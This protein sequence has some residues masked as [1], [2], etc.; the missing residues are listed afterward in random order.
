[1]SALADKLALFNDT[2]P[3][4]RART[5]PADWYFEA[6]VYQAEM[7][8]VFRR[9]W[10]ALGCLG[11]GNYLTGTVADEPVLVTQDRD[12]ALRGFYNVCRHRAATIMAGAGTA[13]KLRCRYHGWTYDLAG[14]LRGTPDFDGVEDFCT[15]NHGLQP[16]RAERFGPLVFLN[17]EDSEPRS[18]TDSLAPLTATMLDGLL[19]QCRKT[20]A[21]PCNWKVFVDNYL[22]GGY[23]V[24]T[25]HPGLA[26]AI[27]YHHYRTLVFEQ[28][29]VQTSPVDSGDALRQGT[30]R[31]WWVFPNLM[32]N[33]YDGLADTNIVV[34]R[35]PDR[36]EVIFD[37][38]FADTISESERQRSIAVA[39]Q[40]QAEDADICAEV[41]QGLHSRSYNT[42][43]FSVKREVAGYH[44][45]RLLVQCL[46]N[47]PASDVGAGAMI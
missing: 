21:V 11:D 23:H 38:Y 15:A 30:A 17:L 36:C 35:G 20:F 27:D 25:I 22:D 44:F 3:L 13:T 26:Q 10:Q 2:L 42:G 9:T 37:F 45:H 29:S 33:L 4:E 8:R 41:Q 6:D 12:G 5:I 40:I 47:D 24:S 43:R 34:P 46:R 18:L 39:E 19:F 16:I 31:Y 7:E 28:T 14:R 1:M 32:L